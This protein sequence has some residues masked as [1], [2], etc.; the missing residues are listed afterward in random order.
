MKLQ[1]AAMTA[2]CVVAPAM[3]ADPGLLQYVPAD[4]KSVAG[5]YVDRAIGSPMGLF[6]QAQGLT[7]NPELQKFIT[8]TGFDPKRDLRE[9]VVASSDPQGHKNGLVIARGQFDIAQIGALAS[10]KGSS[11]ESYEGVDVYTGTRRATKAFAFPE[12]TIALIGDAV[13]VKAA[14]DNRRQSGALDPRL[15]TKL[16]AASSRYDLWFASTGPQKIALGRAFNSQDAVDLISGGLTLGSVVQLNAE[17]VMR[18]EKDAQG[19]IGVIKLFS[20]LA[21]LQQQNNPEIARLAAILNTA[22]T[23]VEGTTVLFSISAP[24]SDLELLFR[25]PRRTAVTRQ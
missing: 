2:L 19:L 18:S 3:A 17:A 7:D 24:Q 4:S 11:K 13:S 6:L 5:I 23:K 21:Q 15:S 22:E 9:V 10:M 25:G 20:G 16:Q 14:I 12:P 1:I 8:A